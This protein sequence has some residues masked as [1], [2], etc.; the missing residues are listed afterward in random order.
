MSNVVPFNEDGSSMTIP[1][2]AVSLSEL[3]R[4]LNS[5]VMDCEPL[6]RRIYVN[7]GLDGICS[8]VLY[9][10]SKLIQFERQVEWKGDVI[11]ALRKINE[12]NRDIIMVRFFLHGNDVIAAD[13]FMSYDGGLHV[14]QFIKQLRRFAKIA[15]EVA[16]DTFRVE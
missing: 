7:D 5:V 1:E 10:E 16:N 3:V 11:G 2:K 15:T 12:V 9:E 14:R 6:E 13:H 4:V 8:L